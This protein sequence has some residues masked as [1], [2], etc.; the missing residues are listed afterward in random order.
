LS[1]QPI[2]EVLG[3]PTN[4]S[5]V[6]GIP[7]LGIIFWII[8]QVLLTIPSLWYSRRREKAADL[9]ASSYMKEST[10]TNS[11]MMKMADQNLADINPPWWEKLLFMSHPPIVERMKKSE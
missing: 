10:I 5:M 3:Y 4:I 8:N 9:F 1:Y 6:S 2:A 11:L 7:V